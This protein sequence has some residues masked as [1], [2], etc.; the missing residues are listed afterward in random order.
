VQLLG[1]RHFAVHLRLLLSGTVIKSRVVKLRRQLGNLFVIRRRKRDSA[2]RL[3]D[4]EEITVTQTC[5][6]CPGFDGRRDLATLDRR[7]IAW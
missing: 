2:T 7:K 5:N 6:L 4:L 3:L 1:C